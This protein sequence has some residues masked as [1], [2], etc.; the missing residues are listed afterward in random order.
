MPHTPAKEFA[1]QISHGTPQA[2]V[3][4]VF[5]RCTLRAMQSVESLPRSARWSS[6]TTRILMV[7]AVSAATACRHGGGPESGPS[8]AMVNAP[9]GAEVE[10]PKPPPYR[11]SHP[12]DALAPSE[13]AA[14]ARLVAAKLGAEQKALYPLIELIEPPKADVL[15]WRKGD[16]ITR[17]ARAYV[18]SRLANFV[19]TVDLSADR[20]EG[21]SPATGEPMILFEEFIGATEAALKNPELVAALA[22]R[23]LKP[24]QVYCLPLTAGN[25]FDGETKGKRLMKVPCFLLPKASSNWFSRPVEG[26]FATI[27]LNT[28]SVVSVSDSGVVPI[29]TDAWGYTDAEIAKRYGLRPPSAATSK[30]PGKSA[31]KIDG[32]Q[33][34]W[35]MWRFHLRTEKRAGVVLSLIQA[36]DQDRWRSVL[37]QAH[38]SEVFVPYMDPGGAFYWRTYMDSGEYGFG[39][40]MSPLRRGTDCPASAMYLPARVHT[41]AGDPLQTPD[42]I[43]IF[44]RKTGDAAWRHFEV[45]AQEKGPV[46]AEGRPWTELVVRSAS[47]VGNYDYFVDYVFQQ[48]G[49]VRIM[50]GSTGIDA[51]KGVAARSM[52]D[53]TA[54]DDTRYGTLIAPNLVAPNHDHFFNFRLDFDIDGQANNFMRTALVPGKPK[55]G[56][57][58]RSFWETEMSMPTTEDEAQ[59][60]VSYETPAMYHV[61]N[62]NTESALGHAPTYMIAP[63]GGI[64]YSPL[65]VANDPPMVRN[66]YIDKTYWVTPYDPAQ[67]YAGGTYAFQSDG[68]DSLPSWTKAKRSVDNTD[69]V[70]WV[71][72]GFHHVPHMEDWPVMPTMWKGMMLAPF[73][74]FDHNPGITI[75][76]ATP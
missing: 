37:Y 45:F 4:V 28:M 11:V 10:A 50:I 20:I 2:S 67:R 72:L 3:P 6:W 52:Q 58:R 70:V 75:P 54:A 26:L 8:S 38:L 39:L 34:E 59:Y 65:D 64:A 21:W 30:R 13:Y 23:E 44:E 57:L 5:N 16:P 12:L 29:A 7:A 73:N 69:I 32:S 53:P 55:K 60:R 74:F 66:A 15:R 61:G 62:R 40:F 1:T 24:D 19:A 47:Q 36:Q 51:V 49:K 68:S 9:N 71:T 33:I 14:V 27:D 31:V 43:C 25:F 76:S 63:L 35:D 18:R 46:P 22:K 56:A 17:R 41:D 42:A 48:D